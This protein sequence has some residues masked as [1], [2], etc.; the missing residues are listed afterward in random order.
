MSI[1]HK[2]K[3]KGFALIELIIV[4]AIL[5]ILAIIA[6]P[7]IVGIIDSARESTDLTNLGTLNSVTSYYGLNKNITNDDIFDGFNTELSRMQELVT[8]GYLTETL[9]AQQKDMEFLWHI[10]SQKWITSEASSPPPPPPPPPP[11]VSPSA[12]Y[13]EYTGGTIT[14]YNTDGG[15]DVV[16]PSSLGGVTI[17][18]IDTN[19]FKNKN[20]TSVLI[21]DSITLIDTHAFENNNLT[22]VIIPDSV[23]VK[24]KAFDSNNIINI[25]IGN[26]VNI[27]NN[28]STMGVYGDSFK[29]LY[30]SPSGGKGTYIYS[31]GS[32]VK[33]P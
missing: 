11:P 18:K 12:I 1:K 20:L 28:S 15:S 3:K 7:R 8:S 22:S 9:T 32:W 5:A 13:F 31:A 24:T 23:E 14:G 17:T 25:T 10:P 2:M 26:S 30:E 19:A 33:Q 4:I 16:I 21:P 27:S 6:I 29:T